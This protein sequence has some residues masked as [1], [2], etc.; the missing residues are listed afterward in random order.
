M[1]QKLNLNKKN[2][3]FTLIELLIV[4]AIVGLLSSIVMTSVAKARSNARDIRRKADLLQINTALQAYYIDTG[5]MPINRA[6]PS[7]CCYWADNQPNFLAELIPNYLA[8]VPT[9]PLSNGGYRYYYY[10]YGKDPCGGTFVL[11]NMENL[12]NQS[13]NMQELA[14][15]NTSWNSAR[16]GHCLAGQYLYCVW[17]KE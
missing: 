2:S 9:D 17:Q 7:G 6:T 14:G 8:K 10:D 16:N 5:T 12:N 11:A 1:T 13:A 15:C 4:I 3:A